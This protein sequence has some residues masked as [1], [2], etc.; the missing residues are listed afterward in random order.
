MTTTVSRR[1]WLACCTA[2]AGSM[3]L[4]S[5]G[6]SSRGDAGWALVPAAPE[7]ATLR[8]CFNE[9]PHGPPASAVRAAQAAL[10]RANRYADSEEFDGLAGLIAEQERVTPAHVLLGTGSSELLALAAIACF[11]GGGE[12]VTADPTFP[13]LVNMAERLGAR[14]RRIPLDLRGVHD[15]DA[16]AEA[17]GN[18]TR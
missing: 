6:R 4:P 12:L 10:N 1:D 17:V 11:R 3:A 7:P 16:M 2:L 8:L 9:N 13:H 18:E 15:L 14:V 5:T